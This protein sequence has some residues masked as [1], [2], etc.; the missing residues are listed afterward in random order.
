VQSA[1]TRGLV[2]ADSTGEGFPDSRFEAARLQAKLSVEELWVRYVAA[3]GHADIIDIDAHLKGLVALDP[4]ES[5]TLAWTLN[6]RLDELGAP[7]IPY[8]KKSRPTSES[9]RSVIADLLRDGWDPS[10]GGTP[11][12]AR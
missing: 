10:Q 8:L 5:D 3:G 7:R 12:T 2:I 4:A 1:F 9:L 11:P 6:E